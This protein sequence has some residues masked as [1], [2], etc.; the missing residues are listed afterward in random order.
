MWEHL[1]RII[2]PNGVIVMT[3]SQPF[4]TILIASNMKMFKYDWIW[5]KGNTTGFLNAN[6]MPLRGHEEVLVFSEAKNGRHT[7]NPQKTKGLMRK[8]GGYHNKKAELYGDF[9]SKPV[10]N[11]IYHPTSILDV[12]TVYRNKNVHPTQKPVALMEY[13]IKTYTN[14][15]ETVLDFTCGSGTTCVACVRTGRKYIGIE[16]DEKYFNIA[17]KR[18]SEEMNNL[19]HN[20]P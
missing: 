11:D 17:N 15:G 9:K 7:Y 8:K 3:A 19:F 20:N 14:E 4:T 1:K 12:G 10:V 13:L 18:I 5:S 2:K 6:K 16:K